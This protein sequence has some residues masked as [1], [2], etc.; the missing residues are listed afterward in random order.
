MPES[1]QPMAPHHKEDIER[2][3]RFL[4]EFSK[5]SDRAAVI[6]GAAR[7]DE[8]LGQLLSATLLPCTSSS[9]DL[10]DSDR[11]LGTLGARILACGRLGLIDDKLIHA[12]QLVKRIRNAFAHEGIGTTLDAGTHADRVRELVQPFRRYEKFQRMRALVAKNHQGYSAEFRT[13]LA[14]L[15]GRLEGRLQTAQPVS[16]SPTT[17]I[18]SAWESAPDAVEAAQPARAL[19]AKAGE[20]ASDT[21]STL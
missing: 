19:E 10:L 2:F 17:L 18:P 8:S 5:E 16:I 13:V 14:V 21:P 11:A 1:V 6:L 7:L 4:H 15:C 20:S 9:D 3:V 12:L